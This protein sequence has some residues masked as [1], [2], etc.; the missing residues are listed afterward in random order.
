MSV[1]GDGT[2]GWAPRSDPG[3][4]TALPDHDAWSD[5]RRSILE[6]FGDVVHRSPLDAGL[7]PEPGRLVDLA[8]LSRHS[9]AS[10]RQLYALWPVPDDLNA[11]LVG[12]V[13]ER[14]EP[15][16]RPAPKPH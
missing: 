6:R 4:P 5:A 16:P 11:D 15:P 2:A 10:V 13:F 14:H 8:A 3:A 1:E 9:G 7:Q 12:A